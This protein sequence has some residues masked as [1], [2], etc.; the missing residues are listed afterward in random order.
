VQALLR[1]KRSPKQIVGERVIGGKRS[2][3]YET[4]YRRIRADRARGGTL[5]KYMRHMGK[6]WCKRKCSPTTRGRV[7]GKRHISER[8]ASSCVSSKAARPSRPARSYPGP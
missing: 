7:L 4:I 8:P 5:H 3:S 1:R 2:M 6:R